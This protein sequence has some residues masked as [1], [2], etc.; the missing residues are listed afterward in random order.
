MNVRKANV[1]EANANTEN[2]RSEGGEERRI[3]WKAAASLLF[4]CGTPMLKN[5]EMNTGKC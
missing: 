1:Q 5:T 4:Y 2:E 3:Y